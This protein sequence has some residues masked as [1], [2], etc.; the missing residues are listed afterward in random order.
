MI[1]PKLLRAISKS[2]HKINLVKYLEQVKDEL[3][4]IR[5]GDYTNETRKAAID[6]ID[7]LLLDKLRVS[8]QNVDKEID[9]YR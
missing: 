2:D 7:K 4:D 1:D 3:A 8:S 9:D 6:I 5:K